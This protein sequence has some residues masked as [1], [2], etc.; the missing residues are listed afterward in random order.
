MPSK[1]CSDGF[2]GIVSQ[3]DVPYP[4]PSI[5]QASS[6]R[7]T[8]VYFVV[9]QCRFFELPISIASGNLVNSYLFNPVSITATILLCV[10]R[11]NSE[12]CFCND[13]Y[14]LYA[15]LGNLI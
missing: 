4:D 10:V 11:C 2:N 12:F 14:F 7:Q 6:S 13:Y 8:P 15:Y 5:K 1:Q 3:V 9:W